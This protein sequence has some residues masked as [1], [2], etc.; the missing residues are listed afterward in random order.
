MLQ[1]S[2][3]ITPLTTELSFAPASVLSDFSTLG[4]ASGTLTFNNG[5]L[6]SNFRT[7]T[8]E[9]SNTIAIA[10]FT[11]DVSRSLQQLQGTLSFDQG[12][13]ISDLTTPSGDLTGTIPFAETVSNFVENAVKSI[14]GSIPFS[15]GRLVIDVPSLANGT[16]EFGNGALVTNLST[17]IGNYFSS[18]DLEEQVKFNAGSIPGVVNFDDGLVILDLQPQIQDEDIAIPINAISG[19]VAFNNGQATLNIPTPFGTLAT[20]FDL[21]ALVTEAVT[22]AL[23]GSGTVTFN[24]GIATIDTTGGLGIVRT[25]LNLPQ[26]AQDFGSSLAN[27]QGTISFDQGIVT[28][29]LTTPNIVGAIDL[30]AL[31]G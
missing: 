16:I 2:T 29:N 10:P 6:R 5:Q 26:L 8:G 4:R 11:N 19:T 14:S 31:L 21:S 3:L 20:N 1:T 17:P 25:T 27:T 15:D 28:S 13:V 30:S 12:T 23:N 9:T 7:L 22:D 18:I 24:N